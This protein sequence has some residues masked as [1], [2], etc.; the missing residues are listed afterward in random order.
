MLPLHEL[1]SV[2]LDREL[3][4][5]NYILRYATR[6][7]NQVYEFE[8]MLAESLGLSGFQSLPLVHAYMEKSA[9]GDAAHLLCQAVHL[10]PDMRNAIV[11]PL[12]NTKETRNDIIIIIN[13]LNNVFN[14]DCHIRSVSDRL[15]LIRLKHCEAPDDYPHYLSVLGKKADQYLEQSKQRLPW[16]RLINEIQMFMHAHEIN[17]KRLKKGLLSINS[18]WCWGGGQLPELHENDIHWYSSDDS[19]N[20]FAGKLGIS[21]SELEAFADND[22]RDHAVC[23]ELSILETLKSVREENLRLLLSRMEQQ[24]FK[25]AIHRVKSQ[26]CS[27]KLRTSYRYDFILSAFSSFRFWKQERSLHHFS[28]E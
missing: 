25:P 16:Y 19:L 7:D 21:N 2:F 12:D 14:V 18:L 9:S 20:R 27:L 8:P 13:D 10:K 6:V 22:D 1:D 23:I 11:L 17:Q 3:P 5:L 15:W 28:G 4:A 26:R 24:L